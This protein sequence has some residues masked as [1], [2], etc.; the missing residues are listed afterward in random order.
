MVTQ[1]QFMTSG[2]TLVAR[3]PFIGFFYLSARGRG[4]GQLRLPAP[5]LKLPQGEGACGTK[6]YLTS[7]LRL[8]WRY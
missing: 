1:T 8:K 2:D 3:T 5:T 4:G 6:G 7:A